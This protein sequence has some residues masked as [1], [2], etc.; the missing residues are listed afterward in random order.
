[1]KNFAVLHYQKNSGSS[2]GALGLH[3]MRGRVNEQGEWV[4]NIPMNADPAR[5]HLNRQLVDPDGSASLEHR[6]T[7]RI[8][9][10]LGN[11]KVKDN[12]VRSVNVI[13]SMSPDAA[14]RI[15]QEGQLDDWCH[16]S[17]QWLQKTHG[18]DN[19]VSAVLHMDEKTPHIHATLVPIVSG[20]SKRQ[21]YD[22]AKAQDAIAD[23]KEV[24]RKRKYKKAS[25]DVQR[26]C[27]ADVM[28]RTGLKSYQTKYAEAMAPFG[29][30]RGIDG[31]TARHIDIN[32][33]YKDLVVQY[34]DKQMDLHRIEEEIRKKTTILA[35]AKATLHGSFEGAKDLFVGKSKRAE[36]KAIQEADKM[37]RAAIVIKQEAQKRIAEARAKEKESREECVGLRKELMRVQEETCKLRE[38]GDKYKS[39]K[40]EMNG[41]KSNLENVLK[42][43]QDTA[44]D[45][46]SAIYL[47]AGYEVQMQ[48]YLHEG[49][50][51]SFTDKKPIRL[52]WH[53]NHL[54]AFLACGWESF[55]RWL[56][57]ALTNRLF[58]IDGIPNN[59]KKKNQGIRR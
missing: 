11:R 48:S 33:W 9:D 17:L 10:A 57:E 52:R 3:I 55:R 38:I 1:M 39:L 13:L 40:R 46:Q 34:Q 51:I 54:Q 49:K 58:S 47:A 24:K 56:K 21:K 26:L 29:L 27:A 43:T 16:S 50:E 15:M 19:V 7:T 37:K 4:P 36:Q 32:D 23:G 31:S 35:K 14:S 2:S 30:V 25:Q 22:E 5:S 20:K 28:T 59:P 44:I 8:K 45:T 41:I 18:A 42:E 6:V 53:D 12:Q